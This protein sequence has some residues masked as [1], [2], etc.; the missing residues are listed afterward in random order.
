MTT[1]PAFLDKARS[2][3]TGR[4]RVP[5]KVTV[6]R[7][8]TRLVRADP[9]W[10]WLTRLVWAYVALYCI[11]SL[12]PIEIPADLHVWFAEFGFLFPGLAVAALS[13]RAAFGP[14]ASP[15]SRRGWLW[16]AAA[17]LLFWVGDTL[18]VI[19][20]TVLQVQASPSLADVGY[21]IYY[22]L[23][24][25]GLLSF[26]RVLSSR[27]ERI[28]FALDSLTVALGG[29]MA[30][31]F[32]AFAPIVSSEPSDA[33]STV[34]A[35]A[36]PIGDLV[37]LLGVGVIAA[38]RS[39]ALTR[40]VVAL[41]IGGLVV[42]LAADLVYGTQV[43]VGSF[44]SG[45]WADIL[46]MLAWAILAAAAKF[47]YAGGSAAPDPTNTRPVRDSVP[48]LPY[49][50]VGLGYSI[51]LIDI[52]FGETVT[53]TMS[54]LALGAGCLTALVVARQIS[55]VR[56]SLR[57][58]ALEATRRS[59]ARF[60]SLVQ[61][62][63]DMIVVI[64]GLGRISFATHSLE[65]ILGHAMSELVGAPLTDYAQPSDRQLIAQLLAAV[66]GT[67]EATATYEIRLIRRDGRPLTV[68]ASA[69]NLLDDPDIAGSVVTIHNVDDRK[70]LEVK[71]AHQAHHDPLTGLVD[72]SLFVSSIAAELAHGR[73][74]HGGIG[75]LYLDVDGFKTINDSLGHRAG[76]RA[77]IEVGRRIRRLLR[78]PDLIGRIGGD[79]F[80]VLLTGVVTKE[81]ATEMCQRIWKALEVPFVLDGVEV[82]LSVSIGICLTE[83]TGETPDNLLRNAD[84]AMYG[85]K[86]RGKG[87]FAVFEAGMQLPARE[88]L[89]LGVALRHALE[90]DEF[91]VYYQPIVELSTCHAVGAEALIRWH[92]NG[93]ELVLPSTFIGFAEETGLIVPIGLWVLNQ[94]CAAAQRWTAGGGAN[95]TGDGLPFVTVN[96]SGRQLDDFGFVGDVAEALANSSI[97]PARLV[98][99][100]TE[101]MTMAQP[102]LTIE[103]L[104]ALKALG[105]R[106]AIDDFGTGYSS[107]GYLRRLPVDKVKIDRSFVVDIERATGAALI[108]GIINLTSSLGLSC[109]AEGVETEEQARAL[110]AFGCHAAQGFYFG[111]PAPESEMAATFLAGSLPAA[112]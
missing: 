106:L 80:A 12:A 14:H 18:Y 7:S 49:V 93:R 82:A 32:F 59:E 83:S 98:L 69:R 75:L 101:S 48:M 78:P 3:L 111:R 28:R 81:S 45:E 26:P 56:E 90:R 96:V 63:S 61:N 76:D 54:G 50:A 37:L 16:L 24:L 29:A 99:E 74:G 87:G 86:L 67:P 112:A 102:E 21:L 89:D 88:R 64:D 34:L 92:R 2:D 15:A 53:L 13:A 72:R 110:Q 22:P 17:F 71:L 4:E 104:R 108:N 6:S 33:L 42:S 65:R 44:I 66:A 55:T 91:E 51:M 103:R 31:W 105:V 47:A 20:D 58:G 39:P 68:E 25:L 85:A 97:D 84:V 46:Y 73:E 57:L 95:R 70:R 107:L 40:R 38:R 35:T 1:Q 36:Y 9:L 8:M 10:K 94:V 30:V 19:Y 43:V 23:L 11:N 41:L 27:A 62:A 60:R 5:L 52:G 79:E 109:V 77:L 100:I